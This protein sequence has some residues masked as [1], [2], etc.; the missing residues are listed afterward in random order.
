MGFIQDYLTYVAIITGIAMIRLAVY[1]ATTPLDKYGGRKEEYSNPG[2]DMNIIE[3]IKQLYNL[4]KY[5]N[6]FISHYQPFIWPLLRSI[7][8]L[9]SADFF[10]F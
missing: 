6:V 10:A 4:S 3:K 9:I 5:P 2:K 7:I 8:S 1:Y